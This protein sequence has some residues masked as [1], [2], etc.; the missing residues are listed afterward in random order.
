MI[1]GFDTATP[2]VTV[3]LWADGQVLGRADSDEAMRHGEDLG[4]GIAHALHEA[5]ATSSDISAIAV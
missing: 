5:G 1:L 3:A 2:R 4:P